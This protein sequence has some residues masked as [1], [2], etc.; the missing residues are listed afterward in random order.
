MF[1]VG[2]LL[3]CVCWLLFECC[4]FGV[5][6]VLR[7]LFV[8]CWLLLFARVLLFVL[9]LYMCCAKCYVLFGAIC[10]VVVVCGVLWSV[11]C[12]L[13]VV[14]VVCCML[15]SVVCCVLCVG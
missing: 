2:G 11:R 14:C 13:F 7:V 6:R 9:L 1:V 15:L 12:A 5:C 10:L 3:C 4:S 8:G